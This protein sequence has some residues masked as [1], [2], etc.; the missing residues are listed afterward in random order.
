MDASAQRHNVAKDFDGSQELEEKISAVECTCGR[1]GGRAQQV[2]MPRIGN[3]GHNCD[4]IRF[5]GDAACIVYDK[6]D[7]KVK[8]WDAPL[9]FRDGD[10]K[11]FS[12]LR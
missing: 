3:S 5:H 6:E 4:A 12:L 1:G 7:C 10:S 11:S 9:S 2:A 8:D